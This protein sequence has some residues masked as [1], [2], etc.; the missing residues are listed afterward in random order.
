MEV[1]T[2]TPGMSVPLSAASVINMNNSSDM[3]ITCMNMICLFKIKNKI[4]NYVK[5]M[6]KI[7]NYVN[8]N[9]A[10]TFIYAIDALTVSFLK[11]VNS[12]HSL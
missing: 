4:S 10:S 7:S 2:D 12:L 1:S 11:E 8:F 5:I 6:H 3:T 9:G